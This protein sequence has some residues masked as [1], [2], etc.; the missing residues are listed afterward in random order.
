MKKY[1]LI[2]LLCTFFISSLT[3]AQSNLK[4]EYILSMSQPHT[5]YFEVEINVNGYDKN[6]IDFV[7]P[8]WAPGSYLIREF[9]KN[10]DFFQAYDDK[11]KPL[12]FEKTN[13]YTWKVYLN[14]SKSV[15]V[16]YKV[17]AFELSVRTSFI[18]ASHGYI[19]GSSIFMYLKGMKDSPSTL[20][21]IPFKDWKKVSTGLTPIEGNNQEYSVPNYD[22][23]ADSPIE[24]GN[25]T[26][27][28]FTAA[29][30]PHNIV[31]YGDGNYNIDSLK[32]QMAK[33]VE[34]S[35]NIFGENPNKEYTFFVHNLGNRGGG[36]E[37][38][39][40]TTLQFKRW[41]YDTENR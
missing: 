9:S 26:V 40:S 10:V 33:I 19:N 41:S 34:T 8:V 4:I 22:I 27:Y 24:I 37:H 15:S 18:D 6:V 32:I 21:I 7:M 11:N 23:L 13:K 20:K 16:K 30:I 36:L 35:T 3:I 38:L 28:Q 29:G 14:K 25:Q 12:L 1:S 5:H 17:Y 31:M 39:N 2:I